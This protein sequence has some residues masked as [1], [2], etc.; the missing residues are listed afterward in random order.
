MRLRLRDSF[1]SIEAERDRLHRLLDALEEG[2]IAIDEQLVVVS[3]NEPARE[4][5]AAVGLHER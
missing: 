1:Q 5:F 2:V 3:A 4:L